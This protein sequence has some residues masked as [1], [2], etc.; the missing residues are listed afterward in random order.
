[1]AKQVVP[2]EFVLDDMS[3]VAG[4]REWLRGTLPDECPVRDECVL[5]AS[6]LAANVVEHGGGGAVALMIV[7]RMGSV[8]GVLVH[9]AAPVGIPRSDPSALLEIERLLAAEADAVLAPEEL[10]EAG[11]G[12]AV[13]SLVCG[14]ALEVVQRTDCTMS[15]WE[16]AGC[17]CEET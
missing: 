6:E 14:G 8:R 2:R 3:A 10:A 15:R 16:L 13:A 11:R 12:L 4:V 5:V 7:H 17:G 9:H 1:M